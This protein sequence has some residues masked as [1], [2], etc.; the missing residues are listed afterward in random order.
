MKRDVLDDTVALVENAEHRHTLWHRSDSAVIGGGAPLPG[1][2]KR[3]ILLLIALA[4]RDERE[5]EQQ[6]CGGLLHAYSGIQG[7]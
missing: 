3:H 4:A 6:R 1:A 5:R 7:S 2:G